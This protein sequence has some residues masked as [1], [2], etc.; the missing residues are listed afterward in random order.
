MCPVEKFR[1]RGGHYSAHS[2]GS[3]VARISLAHAILSTTLCPD[4]CTLD[5][6]SRLLGLLSFFT[7]FLWWTF[8]PWT[9]Y[10]PIF[11]SITNMCSNTYPLFDLALGCDGTLTIMYPALC[12]VFPPF[13][14]GDPSPLRFA[15][16]E[17]NDEVLCIGRLHPGHGILDFLCLHIGQSRCLDDGMYSLLHV[18]QLRVEL[19]K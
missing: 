12:L 6:S 17:H 2:I 5:H 19:I 1:G 13:H 3:Y 9:K 16:S 4:G 15:Q 7:P 8:S 14:E 10:L 18:E 11:S